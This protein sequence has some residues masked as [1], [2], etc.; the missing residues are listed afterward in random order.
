MTKVSVVVPILNEEGNIRPLSAV[1]CSVLESLNKVYEVV[2]VDDG[3]T[4][5]S[6]NILSEL[7]ASNNRFKIIKF[8]RNFGQTA[9]T[10]AGVNYAKGD[11][12][13]LMDGDLQNDPRDIPILLAKIEAG[14]DAVS[15]WRRKRQ[16]P[17]LFKKV[18]SYVANK[19]ISLVTGVK[20]HDFGCTLKAYKKEVIKGID[21]YGEMHRFLPVFASRLGY[22]VAEVEVSHCKR[23]SGN[24]KYGLNR[25]FKVILDLPI[26][27]FLQNY[28]LRPNYIFGGWGL[29]LIFI[30]FLSFIWTTFY[31]IQKGV[32]FSIAIF[33]IG[34]QLLL[35][36]LVLE[37]TMRMYYET[38]FKKTYIIKTTVDFDKKS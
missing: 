37:M 4:D 33:T 18:P 2:F 27:V 14:C 15:G 28:S 23:L 29:A 26:L 13:I 9:A 6:F 36:G 25:I 21:L 1:L 31:Q 34:I 10:A 17:F 8:A 20:L 30:S 19:L 3:S 35:I 22:A 5:N 16:D 32:L 11:I 7:A 24:S 38:T 12:I